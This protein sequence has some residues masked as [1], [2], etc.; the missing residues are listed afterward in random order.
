MIGS[1]SMEDRPHHPIFWRFTGVDIDYGCINGFGAC[2]RT[3]AVKG[4][5]Y[6]TRIVNA[7]CFAPSSAGVDV[8]V[9][10]REV[11]ENVDVGEVVVPCERMQERSETAAAVDWMEVC[12]EGGRERGGGGYGCRWRQQR[13]RVGWA[14]TEARIA[15]LLGRWKSCLRKVCM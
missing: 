8:V 13:Q 7:C 5:S 10:E 1:L 4:V 15:C 14:V 11:R 12:V 3:F 6:Y 9:A 2:A